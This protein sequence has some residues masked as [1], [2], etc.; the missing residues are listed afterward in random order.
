MSYS[1][2][3]LLEIFLNGSLTEDAQK[4]FDALVRRDPAFA[5]KVTNA[6]A[7]SQGEAP[8]ES[9]D[10]ISSKLD[11]KILDLWNDYK[12]FSVERVLKPALKW[13][14]GLSLWLGLSAGAV[15]MWFET[16]HW[17]HWQAESL[18]AEKLKEEA[19]VTAASFKRAKVAAKKAVAK[20]TEVPAVHTEPIAVAS[21]PQEGDSIRLALELDQSKNVDIT[22]MDSKGVLTRHLY[23]GLWKSDQHYVDWDGKNDT[24]TQVPAGDYTVVIDAEGKKQS[25]VITIKS[26]L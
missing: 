18:T 16:A 15:Y 22:V 7:Q 8:Q 21:K 2:E 25:G 6:L 24:G 19:A 1:P 20:K 12:P 13:A 5:E 23:Q 3:T 26:G 14:L 4:A 11:G 9:V 17:I 10:Q